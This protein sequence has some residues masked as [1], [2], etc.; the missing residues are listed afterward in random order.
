M[1]QR[2]AAA[3]LAQRVRRVRRRVEASD[4][5]EDLDAHVRRGDGHLQL[6]G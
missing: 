5:I 6:D 4:R 3:V 2:E 1:D